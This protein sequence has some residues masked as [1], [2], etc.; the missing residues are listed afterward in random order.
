MKLKLYDP[1]PRTPETA[2]RVNVTHNAR[3]AQPV[4]YAPSIE[5]N[6]RKMR[7]FKSGKR[8]ITF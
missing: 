7:V 1:F 3:V 2:P 5:R 4:R 6:L 8:R